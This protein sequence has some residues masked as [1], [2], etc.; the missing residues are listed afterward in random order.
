MVVVQNM[1]LAGPWRAMSVHGADPLGEF[2]MASPGK[3]FFSRIPR[4]G[5]AA[6]RQTGIVMINAFNSINR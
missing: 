5:E 2:R 1:P 4:S 6:V 3:R